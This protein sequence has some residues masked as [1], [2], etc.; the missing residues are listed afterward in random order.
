MFDMSL[1][2]MALFFL[3]PLVLM[4]LAGVGLG[5]FYMIRNRMGGGGY[6]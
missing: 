4:A 3:V 1:G 5:L 6:Y 2:T